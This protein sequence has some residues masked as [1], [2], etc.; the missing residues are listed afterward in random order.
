LKITCFESLTVDAL[1]R[2]LQKSFFL[3]R[4]I[5]REKR[6]Q[7][8]SQC[9]INGQVSIEFEDIHAQQQQ[10]AVKLR[11]DRLRCIES[12]DSRM[13]SDDAKILATAHGMTPNEYLNKLADTLK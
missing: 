10:R 6:F 8:A 2:P 7:V 5:V 3:W 12:G 11:R 4:Q 9:S 1:Q 13:T